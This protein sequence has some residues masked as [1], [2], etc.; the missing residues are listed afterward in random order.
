MGIPLPAF[1]GPYIV[2]LLT[3]LG[4]HVKL[5]FGPA[6]ERAY[7]RALVTL[8]EKKRLQDQE[9]GLHDCEEDGEC[10]SCSPRQAE[11]GVLEP[12]AVQPSSGDME[13][14]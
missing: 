5:R 11:E 3:H 1:Y 12:L 2:G 10:E 9:R 13:E 7:D 14:L 6:R 4:G 8:L